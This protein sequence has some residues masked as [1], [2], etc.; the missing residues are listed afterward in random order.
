MQEILRHGSNVPARSPV[1]AARFVC[2]KCGCEFLADQDGMEPKC[3][4]SRGKVV[5][6]VVVSACPECGAEN[7]PV[8]TVTLREALGLTGTRE[9]ADDS[10]ALSDLPGGVGSGGDGTGGAGGGGRGG[11]GR[12]VAGGEHDA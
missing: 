9:A 5:E 3:F 10:K 2:A 11:A 7:D 1:I 12:S 6:S 8:Q 4:Y